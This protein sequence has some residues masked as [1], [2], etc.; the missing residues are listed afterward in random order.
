MCGIC[1][2]AQKESY[3]P[4][5]NLG[6]M[7]K[8]M[9]HRGPDKTGTWC[10]PGVGLGNA[11]LAVIDLTP[12]GNQPM[13]NEDS[14]VC[15]TYN[16]E[17]YNLSELRDELI[18]KGHHFRSLTDTE[19]IIHLYEEYGK[20]CLGYLRGMFAF[21]I[22]NERRKSLLLAR[23]RIG[24]KP[25]YYAY[26][27]SR[28][29]F[30][31]EIRA[32][33]SSG[34][35]PCE[36]NHQ[37]ILAFFSLGSVPPPLTILQDVKALPPGHYLEVKDGRLNTRSYWHLS[38]QPKERL[39]ENEAAAQLRLLLE[40]VM[41]SHAVSDAPLGAFLSGGV[42]SS[43]IVA[44]LSRLVSRPL[45]T[46][47]ISFPETPYNE[48][49]FAN[50]VAQRFATDHTNYEVTCDDLKGELP[51]IIRAMDQPT[52]DGVNTY[53]VSKA[54]RE[55]GLTVALSGCGSD[56]LFCG[57]PSFREIP[58]L[59]RR[60]TP[61]GRIPVGVRRLFCR[62]LIK[63]I[64]GG[65]T[66]KL[67]NLMPTTLAIEDFYFVWQSYFVDG[68]LSSLINPSLWQPLDLS[69]GAEYVRRVGNRCGG[70]DAVDRI[71][72]LEMMI[73]LSNQLLRDTD[74]MSMAHSL[75]VRVPYLDHILVEFVSR[76]PAELR[77]CK[78]QPKR[79]LL[80]AVGDLLPREVV[81]RKKMGFGFP[82][83]PWLKGGLRP[84]VT[85]VL[86]AEN[87]NRLGILQPGVVDSLWQGFL[88]GKKGIGWSTVWLLLIFQLW[89]KEVFGS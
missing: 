22:W 39:G 7:V 19:A 83:H 17:L 21:A 5:Q 53:F 73:Y 4:P 67:A 62:L 75:E 45:K 77:E 20:D 81:D 54:A 57:Y 52:V 79:L 60:L 82:F 25:L 40:Q 15:I 66:Q 64:L 43:I 37:S 68:A 84:L 29:I 85:E 74:A 3:I 9:A 87:V 23:D 36:V 31:S 48:S 44:L 14:T 76:L 71:S 49:Y 80:R 65:R 33:L 35:I 27:G 34:L 56:E 88:Q 6:S 72:F 86:S 13:T 51:A 32:I 16:G 2:I 26:D 18:R 69:W 55:A 78:G 61:L 50:L 41:S 38:F 89:C 70:V 59:S 10:S 42:D 11:R 58:R 24:I 63:G 47:N 12:A 1:G 46:F 28:L 30:A 8:A